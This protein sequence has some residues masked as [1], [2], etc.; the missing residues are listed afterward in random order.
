MA[1]SFL[2][3]SNMP[4]LLASLLC[5]TALILISLAT[6]YWQTWSLTRQQAQNAAERAMV[7]IDSA[8][9]HSTQAARAA[10][11]L[12]S[13]PCAEVAR[14]LRVLVA[15]S[16]YVR[17]VNLS[18]HGRLYCSSIFDEIDLIDELQDGQR[19]R[20]KLSAVTRLGSKPSLLFYHLSEG[21]HS[22]MVAINPY[23]LSKPL[24]WRLAG[25]HSWV[26]IGKQWLDLKGKVHD[27]QPPTFR[28]FNYQLSSTAFGYSLNQGFP[29]EAVLL[30]TLKKQSTVII[31][32]LTLG[33]LAGLATYRWWSHISTPTQ[34]LK[35]AI[36]KQ[37]FIPYLQPIVYSKSGQLHGCEVLM[38]WQHHRQGLIRPDLF[39]PLAEES[40]LIILMTQTLM[41]QV[42]LEFAPH[43]AQLPPRFHFGFNICAQH[44]Q[45]MSLIDDCRVFLAAFAGNPITLVLELT[46]RELIPPSQLTD[47]LFGE[48]RQMGVKIGLDDFG[49]GHSSLTYL[50]QF[51]VDY[52]KI[53]QSFVAMIGTNALSRHILD[54]TIS[55][56]TRLGLE[57]IAE[58]VETQEQADFLTERNVNYLQGYLYGRPLTPAQFLRL[59]PAVTTEPAARPGSA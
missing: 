6:L 31:L 35:R 34:E 18:R 47:R 46:E 48:L 56:A 24:Q 26:Q 36:I 42:R 44:C 22:V 21:D 16:P 54:S 30:L 13:R 37:E 57:T 43:V 7:Q 3:R 9:L 23:H 15:T 1:L 32:I 53:D 49:T 14:E 8:L 45:E 11:P 52:L 27:G 4:R 20:F 25:A 12:A 55:L 38:R 51:H 28:G 29:L 19:E 41:Q 39:I 59:L 33:G 40:G 50:Q 2:R 10:L 5:C 17:S 58:G